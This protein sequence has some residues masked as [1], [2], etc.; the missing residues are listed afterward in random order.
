MPVDVFEC[1]D[2][3]GRN[4]ILVVVVVVVDGGGIERLSPQLKV[5]E[6]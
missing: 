5:D 3:G 1:S 6:L 4:V 2:F